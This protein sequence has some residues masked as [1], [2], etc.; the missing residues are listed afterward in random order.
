MVYN[1]L[2]M[3]NV[4]DFIVEEIIELDKKPGDYLYV[5][6]IKKNLN[7]LDVL[8]K[9]AE[10]LNIQRSNIS[11]AGNKD[12]NA[13][14]TQYI[15]L[16]K[17]RKDQLKKFNMPNVSLIPLHYGSR[18]VFL[19]SLIGNHFKIRID[20]KIKKR[21]RFDYLV[22]YFGEQRFSSNNKDVGKALLLRD[23]R[24][25]CN[26]INNDKTN[27]YLKT[28]PGDFIGAL[29]T[30]DRSLLSLYINAF[31]AYI[32]N[33]VAKSIIR[34]MYKKYI[35]YDN[36]FFIERPKSN[37]II[38]LISY[39]TIFKNNFIKKYYI[40][41][42][43]KEKINLSYYFIKEFPNITFKTNSRPLFIKVKSL[44]IFGEFIE[45]DLPK[46]SYATVFISNLKALNK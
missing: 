44:K 29:K 21:L 40:D 12:K 39:D 26:L 18:P 9:I 13:L 46:G 6:L 15:S 11:F 27:N 36:L 17:V 4:K 35:N 42:L 34:N 33:E 25:A 45:F 24:K 41:L 14:T 20:F 22:N 30:I 16:Y 19:G 38:P 1:L 10:T 8:N 2:Y 28:K 31:Q 32:W 3:Q 43:N 23:F 5:K 37:F 7:T